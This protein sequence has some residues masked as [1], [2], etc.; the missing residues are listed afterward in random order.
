[1]ERGMRIMN[2]VEFFS[3][4][5]ESYQQLKNIKTR[6]YTTFYLWFCMSVKL[7]P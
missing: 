6:I 2:L 3:Y 7:G 1:M 5:I 4:I